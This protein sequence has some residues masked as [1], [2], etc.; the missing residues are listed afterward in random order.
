MDFSGLAGNNDRLLVT[1]D[2]GAVTIASAKDGDRLQWSN[3]AGQT[4]TVELTGLHHGS[5][6]YQVTETEDG[7]E[8]TLASNPTV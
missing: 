3:A 4:Q 6:G 7:I 1:G 2:V 5:G 8:I